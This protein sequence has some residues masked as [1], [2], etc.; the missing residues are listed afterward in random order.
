MTL[1]GVAKFKRKLTCG[2]KNDI[3]NLVNFNASSG[4]SGNVHFD[5]LLLPIV[6][7]ISAWNCRGIISHGAEKRSKLWRKTD[8]LFEKWH[9]EFKP[10]Q[11]KTLKICTLMGYFWGKYIMFELKRNR[12]VVLWKLTYGF[13][14]DISNLVNLR[15]RSWK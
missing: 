6:Y 7:K 5:V 9:E 10:E 4:R 2:L 11:W 8:F 3:R 15:T 14:N 1:R 13:K 12:G